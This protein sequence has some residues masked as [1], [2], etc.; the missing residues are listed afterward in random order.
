MLSVLRGLVRERTSSPLA[1][2][3]PWIWLVATGRA[4]FNVEI[5]AALTLRFGLGNGS[6]LSCTLRLF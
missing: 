3:F 1:T 2:V 6:H 4:C 5:D